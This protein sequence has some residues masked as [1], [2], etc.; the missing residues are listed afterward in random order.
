MIPK[1]LIC[2][3]AA[4][5]L[6]ILDKSGVTGVLYD[7]LT[8]TLEVDTAVVIIL[9]QPVTVNVGTPNLLKADNSGGFVK[10]IALQGD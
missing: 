3:P 10:Y 5:D 1:L 9:P 4:A 8:I 7:E 2:C 6:V